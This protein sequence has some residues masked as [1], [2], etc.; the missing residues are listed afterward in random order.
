MK[1]SEYHKII[2]TQNIFNYLEFGNKHQKTILCLHGYA[3]TAEMYLK[4][5]KILSHDYHII[6]LDFPMS[7][8]N[9]YSYSLDTLTEYVLDFI[10]QKNLTDFDLFGFSLG[11]IVALNVASKNNNI[12]KLY[13]ANII[14]SILCNSIE[15]SI[16]SLIYPILKTK[17]FCLLFSKFRTNPFLMSKIAVKKDK[18]ILLRMKQNYYSIFSTVFGFGSVDLCEIY[19]KLTYHKILFIFKDD[20]VVN[21]N[22]YRKQIESLTCVKY[23]FEHG[24]HS[25]KAGYWENIFPI[26]RNIS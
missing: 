24:G 25:S 19:N 1:K 6:A 3:D 5:G 16:Y 14:P 23:Y 4:P 26:I 13:I 7:H 9:R 22:R 20:E 11:G 18:N 21:Y 17:L 15:K 10:E 8:Q 12:K 2:S